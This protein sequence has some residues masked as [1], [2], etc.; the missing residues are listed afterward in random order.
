[1]RH[2]VRV[3]LVFCKAV[4]DEVPTQEEISD[5]WKGIVSS[6]GNFDLSDE[7]VQA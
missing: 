1:M 5:F 4:P 6:S 3:G 2:I 7:A